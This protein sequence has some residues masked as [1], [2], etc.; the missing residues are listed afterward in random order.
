MGVTATARASDTTFTWYAP[1]YRAPAWLYPAINASMAES[2]QL[3]KHWTHANDAYWDVDGVPV[4][5]GT[6]SDLDAMGQK[7]SE[8]WMQANCAAGIHRP[9]KIVILTAG[10][11]RSCAQPLNGGNYYAFPAKDDEITLIHEVLEFLIDPA[12]PIAPTRVS[13]HIAEVCDWAEAF[14]HYDR[15]TGSWTPDFVYPSFFTRAKWPYDYFGRVRH[16]ISPKAP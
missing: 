3:V 2:Q 16:P 5:V 4:Y 15:S 13:G 9:H 7:N 6:P 1:N 10:A 14:S 12:F 8:R 11:F